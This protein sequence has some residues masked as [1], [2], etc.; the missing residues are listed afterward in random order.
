MYCFLFTWVILLYYLLS[1]G[2]IRCHIDDLCVIHVF[3][4][5]D[6]CLVALCAI[7]LQKPIILCYEYSIGIDI[8]LDV[9]KSYDFIIICVYGPTGSDG[10]EWMVPT[11]T[12]VAHHFWPFEAKECCMI[13]WGPVQ[14]ANGRPPTRTTSGWAGDPPTDLCL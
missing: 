4:A 12:L 14:P 5:D 8:N 6:L 13:A 7:A 1:Q 10:H 11:R 9:L 2:G 3:Y